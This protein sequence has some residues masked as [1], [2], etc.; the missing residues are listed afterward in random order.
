MFPNAFLG[1]WL[2]V[3]FVSLFLAG[4]GFYCLLYL[5]PRTQQNANVR[6]DIFAVRASYWAIVVGL[7]C[8]T[9]WILSA[10]VIRSLL[11]LKAVQIIH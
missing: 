4:W 1:G 11:M 9:A 5:I 3:P 8:M 2:F 7:L 10:I 6:T